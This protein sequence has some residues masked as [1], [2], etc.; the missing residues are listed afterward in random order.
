MTTQHQDTGLT[1][2]LFRLG[3]LLR[4]NEFRRRIGQ[5]PVPTPHRGQG[6]VLA[7]LR[8]HSPV[9]Q[10][11]LAYLLDIRPQSLGELL[12]KLERAGLITRT[13]V[14]SDRRSMS[15]ELTEAGRAAAERAE[16]AEEGGEEV[17]DVLSEEERATLAGY[18]DRLVDH[19]E[20][21][22]G[23]EGG[24]FGP[25]GWRRPPFGPWGGPGPFGPGRRGFRPGRWGGEWPGGGYC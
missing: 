23:E 15:V 19:L 16:R 10:R 6:R 18:L 17:F 25:G 20:E 22:M 3:M 13:P 11:D 8:M 2:K 7:L 12:T 24:P 1:F 14:E 9:S 5:G 4:R 21:Q